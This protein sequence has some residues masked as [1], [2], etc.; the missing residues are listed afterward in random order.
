MGRG[1]AGIG[2]TDPVSPDP[3]W[4]PQNAPRG[5]LHA[6]IEVCHGAGPVRMPEGRQDFKKLNA[7]GRGRPGHA[8]CEATVIVTSP[9]DV[10]LT[11]GA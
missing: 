2:P 5:T 10:S 1:N 9:P 11:G 8:S 4:W 3:V 7:V 6:P